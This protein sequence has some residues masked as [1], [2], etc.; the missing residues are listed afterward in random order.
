LVYFSG[1]TAAPL[2]G[3][4]L[5]R[6]DGT[7]VGTTIVL[8]TAGAAV[9]SP[10]SLTTFQG[11]L[12][13]VSQGLDGKSLWQVAAKD[14]LARKLLD[15]GPPNL[16]TELAAV[17]ARLYFVRQVSETGAELWALEAIP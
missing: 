10:V 8:D 1:S 12:F 15:L 9:P 6:T 5:W 14:G 3:S 4:V 11:N 7:S 17:G 13:F 2:A 16:T